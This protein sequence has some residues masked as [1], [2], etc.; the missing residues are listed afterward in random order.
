MKGKGG[1]AFLGGGGGGGGGGFH[2]SLSLFLCWIVCWWVFLCLPPPPVNTSTRRNEQKRNII[3][4]SLSFSL[5][6]SLSLPPPFPVRQSLLFVPVSYF[7]LFVQRATFV[8]ATKW[9]QFHSLSFF[10][11]LSRLSISPARL[12]RLGCVVRYSGAWVSTCTESQVKFWRSV[13]ERHRT[14]KVAPFRS[15]SRMGRIGYL[16]KHLESRS[17]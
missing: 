11:L 8:Q 10:F 5:S 13:F 15:T 16:T 3:S 14:T 12:D 4:L 7:C 9:I 17:T 1:L 2:L 6:L